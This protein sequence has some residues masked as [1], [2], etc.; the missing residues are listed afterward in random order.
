[1]IQH[2]TAGGANSDYLAFAAAWSKA[3]LAIASIDL[4][5]HGARSS[6]KLSDRLVDGIRRLAR[7][8]EL[9]LDSWALVEEFARQS[10]S[11]LIRTL[12]ALA[13]LP[14]IDPNRLGFMGFGLGAI[15]GTYLLAH[16]AR[17]RASVLAGVGAGGPPNL[18][19]RRYLDRANEIAPSSTGGRDVLIV[20]AKND[21]RISRKAVDALFDAAPEP[22]ELVRFDGSVRALPQE[23]LAKI[24]GFLRR[25][26][27]F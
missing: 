18:D 26:L 12:D 9:D 8:E 13:A 27:E 7:G 25:T 5:L 1:L 20:A 23:I 3:G 24:E 22:K 6:P 16:N 17:L 11:D 15:A 4:P 14:G 2:A 10:T 21:E 19:P